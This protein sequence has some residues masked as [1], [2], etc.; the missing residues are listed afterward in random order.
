MLAA[1]E[2]R[3]V[4]WMDR[5][6]EAVATE[7]EAATAAAVAGTF[8]NERVA[9]NRQDAF[10]GSTVRAIIAEVDGEANSAGGHYL[11]P[12]PEFGDFVGDEWVARPRRRRPNM[13]R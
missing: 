7:P 1:A 13:S 8:G 3:P 10:S 9:P 12:L 11:Q 5:P 2:I 6:R 4:T